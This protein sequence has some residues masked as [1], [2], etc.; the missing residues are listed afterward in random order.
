MIN[1]ADVGIRETI[2]EIPSNTAYFVMIGA[3]TKITKPAM[4]RYERS[5]LDV[6]VEN[7]TYEMV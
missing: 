5:E 6:Y 1:A 7:I 3:P 4:T 2:N